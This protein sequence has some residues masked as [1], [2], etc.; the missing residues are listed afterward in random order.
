MAKNVTKIDKFLEPIYDFFLSERKNDTLELR[1]AINEKNF[2]QVQY[3]AHRIAGNA[4]SYGLNDLGALG[5]KLETAAKNT[6][7][8]DCEILVSEIEKFMSELEVEFE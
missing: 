3:I 1:K 2:T 7:A 4:G 8:K 6:D 5:E